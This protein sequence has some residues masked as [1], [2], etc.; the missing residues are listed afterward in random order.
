MRWCNLLLTTEGSRFFVI[1]RANS[2]TDEAL[3]I[4]LW[5][6]GRNLAGTLTI[7]QFFG[8]ELLS[9]LESI[10]VG[11]LLLV[12]YEVKVSVG[13]FLNGRIFEHADDLM[14]KQVGRASVEH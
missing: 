9:S 2:L 8:K 3:L 13:F 11:G 14:D 1:C 7:L 6:I 12:G 4:G 5:H 10:I